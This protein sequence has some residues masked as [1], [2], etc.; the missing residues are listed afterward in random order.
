M[1]DAIEALALRRRRRPRILLLVCLGLAVVSVV[2]AAVWG[3]QALRA[4]QP[5]PTRTPGSW[6]FAVNLDPPPG[7]TMYSHGVEAHGEA[8]VLQSEL[9]VECTVTAALASKPD[10][11]RIPP[12]QVS[13]PVRVNGRTA[14]Y[15]TAYRA[16]DGSEDDAGIR[17]AYGD[18]G[19]LDVVCDALVARLTGI[20]IR[21][22]VLDLA[23]RLRFS[24]GEPLLLPVTLDRMPPGFEIIA[25]QYQAGAV[26]LVLT[27]G[28]DLSFPRQALGV[29]VT[30]RKPE[31]DWRSTTVDG[32]P[33][34]FWSVNGSVVLCRPVQS[35]FACIQ[36]SQNAM[37]PERPDPPRQ[38]AE[39]VTDT[40][41][42][43]RLAPDVIDRNTWFEAEETLPS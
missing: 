38:A 22:V 19:V 37:P 42:N 11:L 29:D 5:L 33:A 6:L 31:L 18:G 7:W 40:M 24:T 28:G 12:P 41:R 14:S 25:V 26:E 27:S 43:I 39:L 3:P 1:P 32:A 15:S 16:N 36:L 13:E 21:T 30:P 35:Q 9:G 34:E 23:G 20:E 2:V 8:L 10:E 4:W 17:M